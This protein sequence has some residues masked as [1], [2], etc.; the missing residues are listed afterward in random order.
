MEIFKTFTFDSAHFLPNVPHGHKCKQMHGHTYKMTVYFEGP[1]DK[2]LNWVVDFAEVKNVVKPI[3]DMVDH[4]VL[5]DIPGLEN[6][7]CEGI[8]KWLWEKV[9]A[10]M[11][12]LSKIELCETPTSGVIY[13]GS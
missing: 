4:K 2:D 3:I 12:Q 8:A 1:L 6:P 11:P 13:T 7:T 9:K 5:N 10:N